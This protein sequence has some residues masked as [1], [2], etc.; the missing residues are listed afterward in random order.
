MLQHENKYLMHPR[1]IVV[2]SLFSKGSNFVAT[3]PTST[4]TVALRKLHY[5]DEHNVNEGHNNP[6]K[7]FHTVI[8]RSRDNLLTSSPF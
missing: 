7:V 3:K 2:C 6:K 4:C 1:H 5:Y 8:S